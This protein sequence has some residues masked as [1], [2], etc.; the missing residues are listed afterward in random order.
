M[1]N[2]LE[3]IKKQYQHYKSLGE[4]AIEQIDEAHL[5]WQYNEESNSVA[6]IV[7]HLWGNMQ[8]RFT[9][10][11]TEDGEKEWRKRDEEFEK[12][13]K[14][15]EELFLRWNEGWNRVFETID[16]LKNEDLDK[17]ISLYQ[18]PILVH[19]ALIKFLTHYSY[20]IGQIVFIAKM[21][22]NDRWVSLSIPRKKSQA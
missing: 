8:S 7:Q 5:F 6:I 15:K 12:E 4:K 2:Y 18:K 11:L 17:T 1:E 14:T 9:N 3:N 20:H 10:F 19:E 22:T 13:L 16:T 21:V